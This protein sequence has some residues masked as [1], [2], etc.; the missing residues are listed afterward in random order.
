MK[1]ILFNKNYLLLYFVLI[2]TGIQA[3]DSAVR[4]SITGIRYFSLDNKIPYLLIQTKY[5]LGKK[6]TP[7]KNVPVQLYIDSDS[8]E[9][10][11]LGKVNTGETG[12]ARVVLPAAAKEIWSASP[13]HNFIAISSA[14]KEFDE[15]K[16]ELA[17]TKA[18]ITIDTSSDEETKSI[19]VSVTELKDGG[20]KPA[21]DVEMKIGVKRLASILPV[22]DEETYTTDSSG[23]VLAEFKKD[24]LPGD[25]KG[26]IILVAKVEDNEIY[27]NL[28]V[29]KA[30]PW[31][32]YIKPENNFNKRTL[33][34]TGNKTPLWL[35]FMAW[36]IIAGVWGVLI[37]L[38]YQLVKIK[39]LGRGTV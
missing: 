32:A 18:K 28:I 31:G 19:A 27:G 4:E 5:K 1:K 25:E 35:L 38:I 26:N 21:K 13:Q 9:A 3:Q 16:T 14:G 20:W 2:T 11:L 34:A 36:S 10:N 12:E 39:R 8:G 30:V 23:R 7:V 33:W 22:S 17:V 15:T 6:Y 24:S 37:Y 29:E